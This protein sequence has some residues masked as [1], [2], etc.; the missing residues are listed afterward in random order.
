MFVLDS[1]PP[2]AVV[3]ELHRV[4]DKAEPD[5]H[6]PILEHTGISSHVCTSIIYAT[7]R[8]MLKQIFGA[9]VILIVCIQ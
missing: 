1:D 8:K 2:L 5:T 3:A 6:E 4:D 9:I 7:Y